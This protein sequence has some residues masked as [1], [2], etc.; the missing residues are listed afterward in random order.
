MCHATNIII[1]GELH[2]G[3]SSLVQR[4]LSHVQS[5]FAG[6]YC[7]PIYENEKKVGFGLQKVGNSDI[8]IFAHVDWH[9][10]QFGPFGVR[11]KPFERAAVYVRKMLDS[12]IPL[13][14]ID[15]IGVVEEQVQNYQNAIDELLDSRNMILI[16]VQKRADYFWKRIRKR[17]DVIIFNIDN[18]DHAVVE[19][20]IVQIL[21]KITNAEGGV[22]KKIC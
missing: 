8:D 10:N 1:T 4:V 3:K 15:E 13:F 17:K 9:G 16:V 12:Q 6:L 22:D 5:P 14:V 7:N 21:K 20:D 18:N 2:T 11:L 19:D